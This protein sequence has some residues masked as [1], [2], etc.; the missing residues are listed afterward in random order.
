LSFYPV[1][2]V[3]ELADG[4]V[5]LVVA[6]HLMPRQLQTPGRPVIAMLADGEGRLLP[7]P[8]HLDLAESEGRTIVR[9]LSGTQRRQ[10]LGKRYPELV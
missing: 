4:S 8:R 1:G 2:S 7:T 10:L 9:S 5:G 6:T 3:V